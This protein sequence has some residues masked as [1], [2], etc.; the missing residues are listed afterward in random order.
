MR[1]ACLARFAVCL[2]VS[3]ICGAPVFVPGFEPDLRL[4]TAL[5]PVSMPLFTTRLITRRK[6][7]VIIRSTFITHIPVYVRVLTRCV[8]C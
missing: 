3:D 4:D 7:M 8:A 2:A 6:I 1:A 5:M